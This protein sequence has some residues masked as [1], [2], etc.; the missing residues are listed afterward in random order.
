M[1]QL[2]DGVEVNLSATEA[3]AFE[4][5]RQNLDVEMPTPSVLIPVNGVVA[6][7]KALGFT[8]EQVEAFTAAATT[9]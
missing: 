7:L 1:K 2:I 6:G 8:D 3:A 4:A 5:S 9:G